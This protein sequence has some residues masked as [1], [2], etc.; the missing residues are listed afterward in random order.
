[1]KKI[2]LIFGLVL[3]TILCINMIIM[4]HICCNNPEFKSNDVLG[5]TFLVVVFSLVFFGIR[6][7]RNKQLDGSI[8]FGKAFK[9]GVLIT[10]VASTLYVVIGLLYYYLFLPDFMDHYI[11]H[12]LYMMRE[13]GAT[14]KEIA[15]TTKQLTDFKEMYKNPFFAI[16]FTYLEVFPIGVVVALISSFILKRKPTQ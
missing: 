7:Y 11:Q 14:A 5:Y 2:V 15:D 3:G 10:L 8:S 4:M 1:M 13:S 9:T 12:V 6:N 16:I